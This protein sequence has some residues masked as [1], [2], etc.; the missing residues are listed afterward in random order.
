MQ[1]IRKKYKK[2]IILINFY[3]FLV[4]F[5]IFAIS[6]LIKKSKTFAVLLT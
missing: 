2:S 4:K 3:H 6:N 5:N 1:K